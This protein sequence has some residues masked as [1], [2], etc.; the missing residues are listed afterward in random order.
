MKI[1][2]DV[3]AVL[4]RIKNG[5]FPVVVSGFSFASRFDD[6]IEVPHQIMQ[7]V[8]WTIKMDP[9]GRGHRWVLP[10]NKE[11]NKRLAP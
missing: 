11:G 1:V 5:D 2:L 7:A 6:L 9:P 10:D 4:R 3:E 8:A